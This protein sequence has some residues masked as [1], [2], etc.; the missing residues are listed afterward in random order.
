MSQPLPQFSG[1]PLRLVHITTTPMTL[2]FLRGQV[3]YMKYRG[4][5]VHAVSSPGDLLESFGRDEGMA[6][7]GIPMGRRITPLEDIRALL[8]LTKL[9]RE[10]QPT[11]VHGHT[12]KA[13]LLG[14]FAAWITGVPLR[15]YHLHGLIYPAKKGLKRRVMKWVEKLPGLFSHHTLCVSLSVRR[16]AVKDR[17]IHPKKISV[18]LSGSA[19]G[20]DAENRFNS[21]RLGAEARAKTRRMI[22]CPEN[23][24]VLG[25]VGRIVR[26][27]GVEELVQAWM[28]VR[29][30]YHDLHLVIA[31]PF[32][33]D[34]PISAES[35]SVL[36]TDPRVHLLGWVDDIPE[37]FSAV[38]LVVLPSYREG[39]PN[40][41]LEAAA[42]ALP[43]VAT[44]VGGC[45]DAV[46]DGKTGMLIPPRDS[47][48]LE[49]AVR[50]YLDDA[51]LRR[52]HGLAGRDRV[53]EEFRQEPLWEAIYQEYLKLLQVRSLPV[54]ELESKGYVSSSSRKP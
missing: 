45:P 11:I 50:V 17:L 27:K 5:T 32:E 25:Y 9:L 24:L 51:G 43:V 7:H 1:D 20:V 18:L 38:D 36:R 21:Q 40:V 8:R 29:Q 53:M 12:I 52:K 4:M 42:M 16:I 15:L 44:N 41:P 28:A 46:V 14:M 3:E 48:A 6:V 2:V 54:S 35:A 49:V 39:F 31:G 19:N 47:G 22:G 37:I 26:D 13:G 10:L 33:P 34:D 23:A 30:D